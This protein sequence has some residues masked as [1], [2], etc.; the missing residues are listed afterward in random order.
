MPGPRIMNQSPASGS[1]SSDPISVD[2]G[3][4]RSFAV[5]TNKISKSGPPKHGPAT[6]DVGSSMVRTMAFDLGHI[7]I[8]EEALYNPHRIFPT[9]LV[10]IAAGKTVSGM[11]KYINNRSLAEIT[12]DK[13]SILISSI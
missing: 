1:V 8:T 6:Y 11:F 9:L 5:V 10:V 7:S 4:T 2:S 13:F 3:F 12:I